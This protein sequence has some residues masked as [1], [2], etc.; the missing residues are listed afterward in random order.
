MLSL[1]STSSSTT[2]SSAST[3]LASPSENHI[4]TANSGE[5]DGQPTRVLLLEGLTT[6]LIV[7]I[8][9]NQVCRL[10]VRRGWL[11]DNPVGKL[12]PGEKPR[13]TPKQV[14]ILEGE[15]LAQVLACA[16]ERY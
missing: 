4:R 1:D 2:T 14:S 6:A 13:W 5:A 11:A 10:A 3:S 15:Q 16:V 12:E 7:L 8:A 9:L